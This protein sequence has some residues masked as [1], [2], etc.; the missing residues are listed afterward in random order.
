MM[1]GRSLMCFSLPL[2]ETR[3]LP[4]IATVTACLSTDVPYRGDI[5]ALSTDASP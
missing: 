3:H 2:A 1:F 4:E 5:T